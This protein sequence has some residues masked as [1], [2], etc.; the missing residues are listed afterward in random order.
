M[1]KTGN[2]I[3]NKNDMHIAII[4]LKTKLGCLL[5]LNRNNPSAI[6]NSITNKN[7]L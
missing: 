3:A 6:N 2:K 5:N 4:N 1:V 7:D